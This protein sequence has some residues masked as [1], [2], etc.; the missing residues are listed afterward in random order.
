MV[1]SSR[2]IVGILGRAYCRANGYTNKKY[3]LLVNFYGN[4]RMIFSLM[5]SES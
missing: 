4:Q 2:G 5:L 1:M 3:R